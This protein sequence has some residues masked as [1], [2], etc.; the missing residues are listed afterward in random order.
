MAFEHSTGST[1]TFTCTTNDTVGDYNHAAVVSRMLRERGPPSL[2][3]RLLQEFALA[4]KAKISFACISI[5]LILCTTASHP[6]KYVVAHHATG[7][8]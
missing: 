8:N 3:R 2:K 1:S 5:H 7:I 4:T 6:Y